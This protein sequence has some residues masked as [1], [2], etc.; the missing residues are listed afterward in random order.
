MSDTSVQPDAQR[1]HRQP[2]GLMVE[3]IILIAAVVILFTGLG[4]RS[5]WHSEGRWAEITREM[6][7]AGDYFHPTIGG[8]A[9]FDKP[10]LTYWLVAAV[11]AVTN[12]LDEWTAR[13]PSALSGLIVLLAT[14]SLGRSLWHASVARV[15]GVVL[16]TSYGFLFWSRTA[17][18]DM[19]N[20]AAI[21]LAVA[22][23]WRSAER[24]GFGAFLGFYLIAFLGALTKGLPAVVVP[25]LA[26]APDIVLRRRRR[27]VLTLGHGLALAIGLAVYLAPFW[28]A[29]HTNPDTYESSGLAL[30]FR[31][32]IVRFIQP[33]DHEGPV[34]LYL[35]YLPFL[36][37]PWAPLF[38]ASIIGLFKVR[39]Q[40]DTHTQWLVWAAIVIFA[41]FTVSGSRRGYYI[42][43]LLPLCALMMGVLFSQRRS[44]SLEAVWRHGI[45]AQKILFAVFIVLQL[46]GAPV[47]Y[48]LANGMGFSLPSEFLFSMPVVAVGAVLLGLGVCRFR[49]RG[50]DPR[51]RA[52]SAMSGVAIGLMAGLFCWQRDT[53]E[54]FRTERPFV[55]S[56]AFVTKDVPS[57]HIGVFRNNSAILLFYLNA[58]GPVSI[59]RSAQDLRDFLR[60]DGE[61]V[62]LTLH[63]YAEA[64][65]DTAPNKL[66]EHPDFV[67]RPVP[68]AQEPSSDDWVAWHLRPNARAEQSQV[69]SPETTP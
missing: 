19:E 7:L 24:P 3:L 34:Y 63:R 2:S 18:A 61:R 56:I 6:F 23:Y 65:R 64:A 62:V 8:E 54:V 17:A 20:L 27:Q 32:N 44:G 39:H 15:A 1:V 10:L 31:E 55:K 37:L 57:S 35:Y 58:R 59:L 29:A 42:L 38:V 53:F 49:P 48:F 36:L 9:Y 67:Q 51:A 13:V 52:L 40:L 47:G 11:A 16:L 66:P 69:E 4:V 5:L 33:F 28:Y 25:I 50:L 26:V 41:F 43:P 22:W 14:M 46:V 21:T 12:R 30:V 68:W 45:R 60:G